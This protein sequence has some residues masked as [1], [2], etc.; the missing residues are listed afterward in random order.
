MTRVDHVVYGVRDLDDA[1]TRLRNEHGLDAVAGNRFPGTG[2]ANRVVPLGD[3]Y[4]ELLSIVDRNEAQG[5]PLGQALLALIE[6]GDSL[7]AWA[8]P[9]DDL[10]AVA[11]RLGLEPQ[12]FRMTPPTG[13]T[14]SWRLVGMTEAFAEPG[15]PFFIEWDDRDAYDAMIAR[16]RATARHTNAADGI[17]WI[18]ITGDEQ[19]VR[20]WIG[21]AEAPLRIT[22][23]PPAITAI[24]ITAKDDE[25]TITA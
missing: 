9:S 16:G 12:P 5:S 20:S 22:P 15:L 2:A 21:A 25:I 18:G 6:Q 7:L 14:L 8:L 4:I 13:D 19:R 11:A 24:G 17:A 10:D 3:Q 23:G 1:S